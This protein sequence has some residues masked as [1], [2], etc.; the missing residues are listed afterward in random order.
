MGRRIGTHQVKVIDLLG[1]L[2]RAPRTMS[3]LVELTGMSRDAIH[4][5][6]RLLIEEGLLRKEARFYR[7]K[8]GRVLKYFWSPPCTPQD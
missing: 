5:W 7:T 2:V 1:L 6:L 8:G 3:E 4:G